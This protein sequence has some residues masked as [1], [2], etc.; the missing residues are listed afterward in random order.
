M[1]F[2]WR[3]RTRGLHTSTTGATSASGGVSCTSGKHRHADSAAH[4]ARIL[5]P[6]SVS[7]P[8]KMATDERWPCRRKPCNEGDE[9]REV[10]YFSGAIHLGCGPTPSM[11]HGPGSET[12]GARPRPHCPV[13]ACFSTSPLIQFQRRMVHATSDMIR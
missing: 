7:R 13:D 6:P 8:R 10:I 5:R 9:S 4:V 2:V 12:A 1:K 3:H 11:T